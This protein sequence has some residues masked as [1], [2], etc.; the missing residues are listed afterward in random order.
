MYKTDVSQKLALL[1]FYSTCKGF[2]SVIFSDDSA[3]AIFQSFPFIIYIYI[4]R[5]FIPQFAKVFPAYVSIYMVA[6]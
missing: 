4:L 3:I 1:T 2:S 5:V 6:M